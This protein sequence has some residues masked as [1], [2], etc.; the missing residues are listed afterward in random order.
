MNAPGR[1]SSEV[2]HEHRRVRSDRELPRPESQSGR[3]VRIRRG[4]SGFGPDVHVALSVRCRHARLTS[5]RD[6][7]VGVDRVPSGSRPDIRIATSGRHVLTR[8]RSDEDVFLPRGQILARVR[9]DDDRFRNRIAV[10]RGVV[11]DDDQIVAADDVRA[12]LEPDHDVVAPVGILGSRADAD[13]HVRTSVVRVRSRIRP[14]VRIRVARLGVHA[15]PSSHR[16]VLCAI[17][18]VP[19]GRFAHERRFRR[20]DDVVPAHRPDRRVR[21]SGD[22]SSLRIP[23]DRRVVRGFGGI[24]ARLVPDVR[25]PPDARRVLGGRGADRDGLRGIRDVRARARPHDRD[26]R[27]RRRRFHRV[28][29]HGRVRRPRRPGRPGMS[30]RVETHERIPIGIDEVDVLQLL[31]FIR[32]ST[33]PIFLKS[34][35][36]IHYSWTRKKARELSGGGVS[37]ALNS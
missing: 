9:S 2:P 16:R 14:E 28:G 5:D 19:S 11:P 4:R 32:R 26:R 21:G 24:L 1:V 35:V 3:D 20:V 8:V 34:S 17:P 10:S 13:V 22:R 7:I 23:P 6:V 33:Q 27:T 29:S 18:I 31:R 15:R 12:R 37:T 36:R 30:A 25:G